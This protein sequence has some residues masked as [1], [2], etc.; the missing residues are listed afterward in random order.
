[1]PKRLEGK[2]VAE[3]IYASI[4]E[5]IADS[6]EEKG[7]PPHLVI[8]YSPS[9]EA[10][11]TYVRKKVE[12]CEKL[13]I[14]CTTYEVTP[15]MEYGMVRMSVINLSKKHDVDGVIIQLPLHLDLPDWKKQ[16]LIDCIHP[17]KDVDGMTTASSGLLYKGKRIMWRIPAT[18]QAVLAMIQHYDIQT[19]GRNITILG[20]SDLVGK[21]L[22]HILSSPDFDG[23]VT[24]CHSKTND[25][26]FHI[27]TCDILISALGY[28]WIVSSEFIGAGTDVIDVGITHT[29]SGIRGDVEWSSKAHSQTPVP[30]GI[31]PVTVACLLRNVVYRWRYSDALY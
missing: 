21:P 3:K 18:A 31:G 24:L 4:K 28:P 23:T 20:R 13:G 29:T 25:K 11:C 22:A 9:N 27:E 1:M 15:D 8:L 2:P 7:R 10:S 26:V 14:K 17:D 12:A 19:E 30:G 16:E 6:L 5:M